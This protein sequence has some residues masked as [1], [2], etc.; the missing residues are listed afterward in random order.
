MI[1]LS[2]ARKERLLNNKI[3][4]NEKDYLK[5]ISLIEA[6]DKKLNF[7]DRTCEVKNWLNFLK[8]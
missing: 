4:N 6:E 3:F 1:S 8:N 5:H 2:N 7:K